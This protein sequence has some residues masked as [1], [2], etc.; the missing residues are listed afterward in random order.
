MHSVHVFSCNTGA[1]QNVHKLDFFNRNVFQRLVA[2]R[3]MQPEVCINL[4]VTHRRQ[5]KKQF[6][7]AIDRDLFRYSIETTACRTGFRV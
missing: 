1:A 3:E 4:R 7:G 5:D 6:T 2:F